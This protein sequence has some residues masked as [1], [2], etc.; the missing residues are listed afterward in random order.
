MNNIFVMVTVKSSNFYTEH[1]LKSF[2]KY[3]KLND[4]DEFILIDNDNCKLDIFSSFAKVKILKNLKPLN[5]AENVNQGIDIA[6]KNKKNLFFLT[7]DIIFTKGWV[8]PLLLKNKSI[9]IPSNNQ[10]FNYQSVLGDLKLKTT[11]SLNDFNENYNALEE[12]VEKHKK[13]FKKGQ[14]FQTLLMPFFCFKIPYEILNEIGHFDISYGTGGGEDVDYRIRCSLKNYEVNFILDSYL[15]HF[16]GKSTW[17]IETEEQTKKRNEMYIKIFL[18]KWGSEMNQI[19]I[20]RES[21]SHIIDE[22]NLQNIFKEG[23]FGEIIRK[24]IL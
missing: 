1:A 6:I 14:Q 11:M 19:F 23:K 9:S 10:I 22:K 21:F 7:N 8:D 12:V 16:H 17:A 24:I 13:K 18:K 5:F 4:D 15:L 3:T 2:F 20:I